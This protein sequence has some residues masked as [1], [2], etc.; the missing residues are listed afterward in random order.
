MSEMLNQQSAEQ[1]AAAETVKK[2]KRQKSKSQLMA[3]AVLDKAYQ[4]TL[5]A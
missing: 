1:A 5:D 4:D 3:G 2:P